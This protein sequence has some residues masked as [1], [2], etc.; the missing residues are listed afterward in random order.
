[1]ECQSTTIGIPIE[2][3]SD[4]NWDQ[5]LNHV[6]VN[7]MSI[8]MSNINWHSIRCQLISNLMAIDSQLNV[9]WQS[10]WCQLTTN[11]LPIDFQLNA[12]WLTTYGMSIDF[13]LNANWLQ[14]KCWLTS[15]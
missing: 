4:S 9:N 6:S 8:G 2:I 15:N 5:I 3:Q 14:I 7:Q 12:N 1:M 13:Q 11:W 10:I